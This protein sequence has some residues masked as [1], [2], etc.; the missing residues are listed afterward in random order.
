MATL[1][2]KSHI[3]ANEREPDDCPQVSMTNEAGSESGISSESIRCF[4][5]AKRDAARFSDSRPRLEMRIYGT[6][7]FLGRAA[8]R[9]PKENG[10]KEMQAH[11]IINFIGIEGRIAEFR[12]REDLDRGGKGK[13]RPMIPSHP[14]RVALPPSLPPV[15]RRYPH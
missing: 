10:G 7:C 15:A 9:P 2:F 8:R 6:R 11:K 5:A 1:R 3:R 13:L 14:L 4:R 12:P